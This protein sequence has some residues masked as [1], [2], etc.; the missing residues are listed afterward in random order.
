MIVL[1]IILVILVDK[2][3]QKKLMELLSMCFVNMGDL[4]RYLRDI[5][6][7]ASELCEDETDY[8][9]RAQEWYTHV[10][11]IIYNYLMLAF[12]L[13]LSFFLGVFDESKCWTSLK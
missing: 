9:Y 7:K 11:T 5:Y 4:Y 10:S 8:F 13:M 3:D 1:Y 6:A 12:K 2:N